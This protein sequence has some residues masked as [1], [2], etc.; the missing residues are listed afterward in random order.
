MSPAHVK[1]EENHF[2]LLTSSCLEERCVQEGKRGNCLFTSL[3]LFVPLAPAYDSG[4]PQPLNCSR[5]GK[6]V[7]INMRGDDDEDFLVR[8]INIIIIMKRRGE[9]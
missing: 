8:R 7:I 3:I 5:R 2:V 9:T 1:R 6:P 4:E